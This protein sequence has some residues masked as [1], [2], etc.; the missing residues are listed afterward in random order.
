MTSGWD[1]GNDR[2][3]DAQVPET[4]V[5]VSERT[6]RSMWWLLTRMTRSG[7]AMCIAG[8]FRGLVTSSSDARCVPAVR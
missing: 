1:N 6:T 7:Q 8:R 2:P 3:G 5:D 4:I